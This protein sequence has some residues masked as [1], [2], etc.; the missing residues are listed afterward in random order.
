M[1]GK[2]TFTYIP[3]GDPLSYDPTGTPTG[4][5]APVDSI[6]LS[7]SISIVTPPR[8]IVQVNTK[9]SDVVGGTVLP[10]FDGGTL[11]A[12]G[13]VTALNFTIT[14]ANGTLDQAGLHTMLTGVLSDAVAGTPGGLTIVNSGAGGSITLSGANTYTGTTTIG[15]GTTVAVNGSLAGTVLVTDGG[16]LRGTGSVGGIGVGAGGV[17][18][19]GNSPGTLVSAGPVVL[20]AGST[21]QFDIDGTGTGSG[22][23][24]FSRIIVTG[25]GNT[26]TAGGTVAPT[27]RGISGAATNT[28]TPVV[29]QAFRVVQAQGGVLGAF[30]GLAQPVGLAANTRFDVVYGGGTV[31]LVVT[32]AQ[33]GALADWSSPMGAA[34]DAVRPAAGAAA[35]AAQSAV[36]GPI[37]GLTAA[38]MLEN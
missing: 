14:G 26:L 13:G 3:L 23:G 1:D 18:A 6:V 2:Y 37:Y 9:I 20:A 24:N 8:N 35:S 15:T 28:F 16:M 33:F 12:N 10:V 7:N 4:D 21:T 25:A 32:P 38:Q 27:L 29:G 11:A 19:P 22:A 30:S 31:D 36:F 5:W 17:L 34:L